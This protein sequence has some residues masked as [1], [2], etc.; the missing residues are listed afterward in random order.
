MK[1]LII[2][3]VVLIVAAAAW[4]LFGNQ[5]NNTSTTSTNN[6][7]NSTNNQ[8]KQQ[9]TPTSQAVATDKVTM[10]NIAFSPADITVKK[11]TTVTWTNNDAVEHTVT[12]DDGQTGPSAPPLSQGQ[13]YTFTFNQAGTFHY[14]CTI[15]SEMTG[16]VT[17]TGS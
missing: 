11:G 7:S 3:V 5:Q 14:H 9:A 2:V 16:T 6:N 13:S 8:S 1:K 12:E 17:V 15:H 10:Q 4:L